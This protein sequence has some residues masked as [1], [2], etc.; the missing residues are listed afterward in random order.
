MLLVHKIFSSKAQPLNEEDK[1]AG[2]DTKLLP[3]PSPS[4]L[5]VLATESGQ[6]PGNRNI[7]H[8]EGTPEGAEQL[9]FI[10]TSLVPTKEKPFYK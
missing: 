2:T 8:H 7:S 9:M 5:A 1:M 3:G 4:S 10:Q 6:R